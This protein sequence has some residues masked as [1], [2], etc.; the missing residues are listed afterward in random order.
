MK[1]GYMQQKFDKYVEMAYVGQ[2][3]PENQLK[4]L[5]RAFIAGIHQCACLAR[6]NPM[7]AILARTSQFA[8]EVHEGL[9]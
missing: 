7:E 8:Q 6:D 9:S 4:E 3:L 5:R 1:K 2:A